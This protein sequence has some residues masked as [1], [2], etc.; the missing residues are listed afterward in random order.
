MSISSLLSSSSAFAMVAN[1]SRNTFFA[2][3]D[4][5]VPI[6]IRVIDNADGTFSLSKS[7]VGTVDISGTGP[8]ATLEEAMS[9]GYTRLGNVL[10]FDSTNAR[11]TSPAISY[12]AIS[13][14]PLIDFMSDICAF[15]THYFYIKDDILVLGDMLLDNSTRSADEYDYFTATYGES[16]AIS[17]LTSRWTTYVAIN[18]A[19]EETGDTEAYVKAIENSVVKSLLTIS[20]GTT[21]GTSAGSLVDTGADFDAD[22]IINGYVAYNVTDDTSTV[23]TTINSTTLSLE[24][25]I[26]ISG[27]NYIVGPSFPYGTEINIEPYH[28][29]KG[30]VMD[31]LTNIL[32]VLNKSTADIK[33]PITAGLPEPG[34]KITF[35]DTQLPFDL[36]TYIRA[37]LITYDF[38]N[39]EILVTGEGL[40]S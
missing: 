27:E 11:A 35:T 15:F 30:N 40:I 4:D 16:K 36:T 7:P 24:E 37:R 18:G 33:L 21:D 1:A 17:Q 13:Q 34:E 31:A 12:W 10:S 23:V 28:T 39:E 26:F 22:G 6:Q 19:D 29:V 9:W 14:K 5:G 20:S 8:A 38:D 2:V 32:S 3:C 25:D